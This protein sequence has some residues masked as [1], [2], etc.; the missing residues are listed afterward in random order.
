[1]PF[2]VK[3]KLPKY[4][5]KYRTTNT[6][7]IDKEIVPVI[8]FLW[9]NKIETLG[10]CSGHNK[11]LPSIVISEHYKK[12]EIREIRKLIFEVDSRRWD[13]FQWKLTKV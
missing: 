5:Q 9:K 7:C 13:I 10:C 6:V 11:A 2:E 8:K 1:M 12:A 4:L 3:L